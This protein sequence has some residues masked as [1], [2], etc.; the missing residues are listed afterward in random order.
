MSMRRNLRAYTARTP[1]IVGWRTGPSE[2]GAMLDIPMLAIGLGC[3]AL[4]ALYGIAGER[5]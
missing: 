4:F 1:A 3:F 2:N 5:L